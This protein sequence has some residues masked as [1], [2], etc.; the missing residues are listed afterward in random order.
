MIYSDF[1]V[2][3]VQVEGYSLQRLLPW[4][5]DELRR[6]LIKQDVS[7]PCWSLLKDRPYLWVATKPMRISIEVNCTKEEFSSYILTYD[8]KAGFI[9]DLASIPRV[10]R[11]LISRND[12]SIIIGATI[13]DINFALCELPF[14]ESNFLFKEMNEYYD[15]GYITSKIVYLAVKTPFAKSH[16]NNDPDKVL[17]AKKHVNLNYSWR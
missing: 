6:E 13:H 2:K 9:T 10:G 14:E 8:I 1:K 7:I 5:Y 3:K 4:N 15:M 12:I 11:F 17:E 16:Y